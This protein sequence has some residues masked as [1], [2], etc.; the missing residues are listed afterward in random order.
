VQ[1]DHHDVGSASLE[2]P[3]SLRQIA[4]IAYHAHVGLLLHSQPQ[5][6]AHD[7]VISHYHHGNCSL[8]LHFTQL[9]VRIDAPVAAGSYADRPA[10]PSS[11]MRLIPKSACDCNVRDRFAGR[12]QHGLGSLNA[13]RGDECHRGQSHSLLERTRKVTFADRNQFRKFIN[14]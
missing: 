11:Q 8:G 13:S 4:G 2:I 6:I 14:I 10:K 3:K 12:Y 5:A 9:Q 1:V 7:G